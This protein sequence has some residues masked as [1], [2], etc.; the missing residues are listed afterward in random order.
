MRPLQRCPICSG[1][2][3]R[4]FAMDAWTP[5]VLHFAQ[6]RCTRCGL[7]MAQ[8]QAT[9]EELDAYYQSSYYQ[10]HQLDPETHWR[11]NVRDYPLYE[12]PLMERLWEGFAPPPGGTVAEVGC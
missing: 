9:E 5:G 2:D 6:A 8:P 11:V 12:L 1:E 10:N 4:P 3:L 7:V